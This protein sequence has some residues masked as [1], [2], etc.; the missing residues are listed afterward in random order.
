MKI[1]FKKI[2][3]N[4]PL[5][6]AETACGHNGDIKK[7]IK[8]I[9]IAKNSGIKAIKFQIFKLDERSV[10]NSKEEKIFKNL[11]LSESE[12]KKAVNWAHKKKLFVF[13]DIF[14]LDSLNLAEKIKVDGYKILF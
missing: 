9:N 12:W 1:E 10:P 13:A 4:N 7:L 11:T 14:G 3:Q 5:L 2:K 6:I 8:L